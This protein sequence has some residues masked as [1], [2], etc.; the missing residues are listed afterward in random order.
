MLAFRPK[1]IRNSYLFTRPRSQSGEIAFLCRRTFPLAGSFPALLESIMHRTRT[2]ALLLS[3]ALPLVAT[4]GLAT[5]GDSA[6]RRPGT[7][8][9]FTPAQQQTAF[10]A[11]SAA[12]Y[13]PTLVE[14]FQDGNFFP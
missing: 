12:G 13:S 9:Y 14:M 3:A 11:A 10:K 8:D 2:I 5:T 4:E 7:V 1:K 6:N